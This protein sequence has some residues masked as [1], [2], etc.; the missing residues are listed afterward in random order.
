MSLGRFAP[1]REFP[2][3]FE[4]EGFLASVAM[5]LDAR[6]VRDFCDDSGPRE[7]P[8]HA[9]R[10]KVALAGARTISLASLSRGLRSVEGVQSSGVGPNCVFGD[11]TN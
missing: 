6:R 8:S 5:K 3:P 1:R 10:L 2:T 11:R 9:Q 4:V 7:S